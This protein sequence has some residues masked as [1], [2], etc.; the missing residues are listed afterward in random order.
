MRIF[1][2]DSKFVTDLL[3]KMIRLNATVYTP[4]LVITGVRNNQAAAIFL[5]SDSL[6]V[7]SHSA[8]MYSFLS[9]L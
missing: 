7:L 3:P 6:N 4:A 5:S 1:P 2:Q 8:G 9:G